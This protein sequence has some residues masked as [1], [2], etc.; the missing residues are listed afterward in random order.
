MYLDVDGGLYLYQ[1]GTDTLNQRLH[2]FL[3][4]TPIV[5]FDSAFPSES[6]YII[7]GN[8]I[9][10]MAINN[11]QDIRLIVRDDSIETSWYAGS[12]KSHI[13]F[14]RNDPDSQEQIYFS[15]P[16]DGGSPIELFRISPWEVDSHNWPYVEIIGED[17]YFSDNALSQTGIISIDGQRETIYPDT[18]IVGLISRSFIQPVRSDNF[19]RY[20]YLLILQ[21]SADSDGYD[22][23]SFNFKTA[24]IER[25]LG[26]LP[27]TAVKSDFI[28][29]LA[30]NGRAI[31]SAQG[32]NSTDIFYI[33]LNQENSLI[34]VTNNNIDEDI[35]RHYWRF[36]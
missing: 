6:I 24:G 19:Q 34:Q 29:T 4:E 28:R 23:Y 10:S 8:T 33:D 12:T 21:P 36:Q 13:L 17:I 18:R 31:F 20:S 22:L 14:E 2:T 15:F 7:D 27:A 30:N 35:V 16:K 9:S 25:I 5:R 11:P 26:H 3:T 1:A 32:E